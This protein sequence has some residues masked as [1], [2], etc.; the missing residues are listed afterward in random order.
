MSRRWFNRYTFD[1]TVLA[2][3]VAVAVVGCSDG[4]SGDVGEVSTAAANSDAATSGGSVAQAASQVENSC[5]VMPTDLVRQYIPDAADPHLEP[6]L[7][8]CSMTNNISVVQIAVQGG[9]GEPDPLDPGETLADMGEK[10]WVQEQIV[11]DAYILVFLGVDDSGF[12][13]TLTVEFA[14]NDGTGHKDA[15]IA[16]ARQIIATL[17]G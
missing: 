13:Q 9:F 6:D 12:Y 5:A 8:N 10:A 1:R 11:D 4:K 17:G 16:I 3:A 2:V 14:G 15:A 7:F